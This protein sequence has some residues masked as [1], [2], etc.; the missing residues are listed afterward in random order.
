MPGESTNT[1][2][3]TSQTP[4]V[5]TPSPPPSGDT[6]QLPRAEYDRL[7]LA[8]EKATSLEKEAADLRTNWEH[9]SRLISRKEEDPSKVMESTRHVMRAAGYEDAAIEAY[10]KQQFA[11]PPNEEDEPPTDER[12]QKKKPSE[13]DQVRAE[14]QQY[15]SQAE[16]REAARLKQTL[17]SEIK[18]VVDTHQDMGKLV[19]AL[20]KFNH[21]EDPQGEKAQK[22]QGELMSTFRE[23][24]NRETLDRLRQRRA[25]AQGAW[26]DEWI[27][28]EAAKAAQAVYGKL[29]RLVPDPS[30]LGR[31]PEID[32][33]ADYFTQTKP[34][35]PPEYKK[36]MKFAEAQGQ[37]RDWITDT[38]TRATLESRQ[39][40][41]V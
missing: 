22:Y 32:T 16:A 28:E 33:D 11:P 25:Q 27:A 6:F 12:G 23:D 3:Q 7:R 34:V 24:V 13:V 2:V 29:K 26:R 39:D 9:A 37:V 14:L 10:L 19:G 1:N 31:V 35:A 21:A 15:Q 30:R 20:V 4:P 8:A 41:P 38:L 40:S 5:Q 36:G 18:Q 17:Q